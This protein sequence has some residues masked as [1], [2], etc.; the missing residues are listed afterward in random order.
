M[1]IVLGCIIAIFCGFYLGYAW[2]GSI[3]FGIIGAFGIGL[4]SL[5]GFGF[6]VVVVL[7]IVTAVIKR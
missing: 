3:F 1:L 6:L 2:T 7:T 4:V 5:T